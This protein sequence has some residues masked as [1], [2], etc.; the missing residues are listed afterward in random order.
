[1]LKLICKLNREEFCSTNNFSRPMRLE[2]V[3]AMVGYW[4]Y[5]N[6]LAS[7]VIT[8]NPKDILCKEVN[9]TK[10]LALNSNLY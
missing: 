8:F 6:P 10:L 2:D 1:M 4:P 3:D 9:K 5:R 7:V